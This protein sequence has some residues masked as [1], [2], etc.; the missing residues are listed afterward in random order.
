MSQK[1]AGCAKTP[2]RVHAD[3]FCSLFQALR[4]F[5][6][7]KIAKNFALLGQPQKIAV[8]SHSLG[9]LLPFPF[10]SRNDRVGVGSRRSSSDAIRFI[11]NL[12]GNSGRSRRAFYVPAKV[13]SSTY[14]FFV[15]RRQ[16]YLVYRAR[17]AQ[18]YLS[19]ETH[20]VMHI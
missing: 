9:G 16:Q 2:A 6:S 3:L 18:L 13:G 12:S 15:L 10:Q 20:A 7:K 5:R 1:G 4:T 17:H 11:N 8:F 19:A 14:C